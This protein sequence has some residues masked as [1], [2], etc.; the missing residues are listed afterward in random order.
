MF[1]AAENTGTGDTSWGWWLF[2]LGCIIVDTFT[3]IPGGNNYTLEVGKDPNFAQSAGA[4][5]QM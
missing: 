5:K 2:S 3:W 1:S 4:Y